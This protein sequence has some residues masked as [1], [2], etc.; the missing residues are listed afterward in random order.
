MNRYLGAFALGVVVSVIL[1]LVTAF[2]GPVL[3]GR[4]VRGVGLFLTVAIIIVYS[5]FLKSLVRLRTLQSYHL[6]GVGVLLLGVGYLLPLVRGQFLT[7]CTIGTQCYT[8]FSAFQV[9]FLSLALSL[10]I[11]A[12]AT[13][14]RVDRL[15]HRRIYWGL[16]VGVLAVV[17][18]FIIL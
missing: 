8:T 12:P 15:E 7:G 2:A 18:A 16:G 4:I 11:L 17:V 10:I 6:L 5:P 14:G 3:A 1:A 9:L 13:Y